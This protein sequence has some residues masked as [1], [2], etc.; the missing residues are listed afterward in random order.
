MWETR[1]RRA[2]VGFAACL[3]VGAAVLMFGGA[4]S[5]ARTTRS[6]HVA[7]S[8]AANVAA[9]KKIV[10][11]GLTVPTGIGVSTPLKHAPAKGIQVAWMQ[12]S[13]AACS[14]I[15]PGFQSAAAALGW[16]L[17][18][19]PFDST[20]PEAGF[21]QAIDTGAK[22]IAITGTTEATIAPQLAEA[23]A[24]GVKVFSCYANDPVDPANDLYFQC[25]DA[26]NQI[27]DG[28]F[29]ADWAIANSE[30]T[31]QTVMFDTPTYATLNSQ[32]QGFQAEMKKRCPKT[33]SVNVVDISLA[34]LIA[35]QV[36]SLVVSYVQSHPQVKYLEFTFSDLPEGVPQALQSAGLL[37]HLKIFGNDFNTDGLEGIL[38]GTETAYTGIPKIYGAWL[39]MDAIARASEGMSLAPDEGKGAVLPEIFIT[40]Q[41]QARAKQYL[42]A[43]QWSGPAGFMQDFEKLWHI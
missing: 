14:T 8:E 10:A 18:V 15:T 33:C 32:V 36:P 29:L 27:E 7:T 42:A 30:G 20:S 19:I 37:S 9:A 1:A 16:K 26:Q 31:A 5:S 22:Y 35:G 41:T 2:G 24:H 17:D 28:A 39:T 40:N 6:A 13:V 12:C 3:A 25:A 11:A 21:Q 4:S 23:K 43:G 34:Q 38:N